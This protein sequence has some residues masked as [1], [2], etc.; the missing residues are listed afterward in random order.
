VGSNVYAN[1]REVSAKADDNKSVCA[2]PDVC[3][4]PPSPPAGPIPIPYP[5]TATA[6]DTSD[7]SK[8]VKIGGDEIGLK[9]KSNY[10][11]SNGDEAATKTLGMGVVTHT[12]QGK[13]KHA[14][15][16]MDVKVEGE[17]VIRFMDITTHNHVNTPNIATVLNLGKQFPALDKPMSCE[18]LE[19]ANKGEKGLQQQDMKP[20]APKKGWTSATA[21]YD[22]PPPIFMKALTS[23]RYMA[24]GKSSGFCKTKTGQDGA[25]PMRACSNTEYPAGNKSAGHC[26]PKIFETVLS[27]AKGAGIGLPAAPGSLG[28]LKMSIDWRPA[29]Q[30]GSLD[31]PCSDFCQESICMAVACGL[32]ILICQRD[33]NG[34]M[35]DRKAPCVDG[36]WQG[37]P[38]LKGLH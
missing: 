38:D 22:G 33:D 24:S 2:M 3:F 26:E 19:E 25:K 31:H 13:M 15:W 32:N 27:A 21:Q 16:S 7:G 10:K 12:I 28:T 6:S 37:S 34:K 36:K 11:S 5:N 20:D 17:N 30:E 23:E 35:A 9:N 14:A 4:S 18:E 8:S 1:G 29:D